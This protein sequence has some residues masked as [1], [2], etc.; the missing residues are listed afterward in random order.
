MKRISTQPRL[1]LAINFFLSFAILLAA[2]AP[3]VAQLTSVPQVIRETVVVEGQV[4]EKVVTATPEP[5]P[6]PPPA[7]QPLEKAR[8]ALNS[9]I[10]Q[11]DPHGVA[12]V[13]QFITLFMGGGQL[14]RLNPD[15]SVVPYLAEKYEVSAD[16][17]IFTITLK[18]D[19]KFSDGSPLTAEDVAY[20]YARSVEMK[21]PRLNLLG[22]VKSF[23]AKDPRTVEITLERPYANLLIGL[24][25]FGN[26][27]FPKA[28]VQAD[29]DFFKKA[30]M[31][32]S[33]Q[34]VLTKWEPGATEWALEENPNFFGGPSMI[35]R[36]EIVAVPD[37]TSRTLQL[38]TGDLDYGYDIPG[39]A[40]AD[41]PQEVK[42]FVVP[43]NGVYVIAINLEAAKT[44]PLGN[45]K[46][47]QAISLA[48]DRKTIQDRAFYG[49]SPVVDGFLY[50]G[51]PEGLAVL[52]N[53]G[54]RDLEAAKKLLAETPYKDGFK[55][56]IQPWGQRPGWTD[57]A[58][59]I[60]ENLGELGIQVTVDP[61]GDA[62]AIALMNSGGYE[63]QFSGN[64]GDPLTYFTQYFTPGGNWNKWLRYN[65]PQ[66]TELVIQAGSTLDREERIKI[67]H[68]MQKLLVEEMPFVPLTERVVLVAS[69]LPRN[70]LCEANLGVGYNPNIATVQ[71]FTSGTGPCK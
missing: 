27:I 66:V 44:S 31:V 13:S 16:G 3:P 71:Q 48:V 54:K 49:I 59:I 20:G 56:T 53:G 41:L 35:K 33:G 40:K 19:L 15:Y 24:S 65:N 29:P 4:I 60:K 9:R 62:D 46:V 5:S 32:G 39:S 47:R 8:L 57:A 7:D 28:K 42:T 1:F 11:M 61:K 55:F 22:P 70:I 18:P 30:P 52:P 21:S 64:L 10:V 69:S 50:K 37:Q 63:T 38:I 67:F 25:D 26:T 68:D 23:T 43:L 14:F 51:P 36:V 12:S 34:Y 2:C 45:P 17:L 58:T 6:A